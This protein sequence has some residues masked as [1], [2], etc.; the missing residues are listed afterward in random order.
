MNWTVEAHSTFAILRCGRRCKRCGLHC[1]FAQ[2][3]SKHDIVRAAASAEWVLYHVRRNLVRQLWLH[4][5]ACKE[6]A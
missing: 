3:V 5:M 1:H 4:R 2:R 6:V